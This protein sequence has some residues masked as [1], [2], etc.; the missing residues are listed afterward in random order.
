MTDI[1][2]LIN[3]LFVLELRG[4][5]LEWTG[6]VGLA[7]ERPWSVSLLLGQ[8]NLG[9][10]ILTATDVIARLL[11]DQ[12]PVVLV[13]LKVSRTTE[14]RD[15]YLEG[16]GLL[17]TI[18]DTLVVAIKLSSERIQGMLQK[19][20][21]LLSLVSSTLNHRAFTPEL[22]KF[23][24]LLLGGPLQLGN[25]ASEVGD[26][27]LEAGDLTSQLGDGLVLRDRD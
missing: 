16:P 27:T 22:G 12:V 3:I 15:H 9:G 14:L 18:N 10:I 26:T 5:L 25:L 4:R 6:H 2:S 8:W 11:D 24:F 7:Q 20:A 21:F 23:G 1:A 19:G 17:E 13:P